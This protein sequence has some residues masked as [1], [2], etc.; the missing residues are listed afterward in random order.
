LCGGGGE[1]VLV[2]GSLWWWWG[3]SIFGGKFVVVVGSLWWWL[4]VPLNYVVTPTSDKYTKMY[5]SYNMSQIS[6]FSVFSLRLVFF[7]YLVDI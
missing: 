2:V 5:C 7:L 1:F 3:V 6:V 4:F